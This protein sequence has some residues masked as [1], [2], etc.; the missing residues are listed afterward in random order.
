MHTICRVCEVKQI[1]NEKELFEVELQLTADNDEQ[2]R[3]LTERMEKEA[4]EFTGW[5]RFGNL[6]VKI[7]QISKAE[8]L[9]L[10][11]LEE[12]SDDD[13]KALYCNQLGVVKDQQGNYPK[14]L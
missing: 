12:T 8:E 9:F 11:L 7:D 13:E 4:A 2:R 10:A 6:L 14:A 1:D 5:Q 3:K